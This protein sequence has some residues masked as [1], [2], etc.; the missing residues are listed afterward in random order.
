MSQPDLFAPPPEPEVCGT[1][2]VWNGRRSISLIGGCSVHGMRA[3]D[4]PPCER[5]FPTLQLNAALYGRGMA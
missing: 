5:W 1:C 3:H 4:A 2:V